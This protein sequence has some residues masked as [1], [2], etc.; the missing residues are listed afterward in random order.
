MDFQTK[1]DEDLIYVF[2]T[3]CSNNFSTTEPLDD[4]IENIHS[5]NLSAIEIDTIIDHDNATDH[6]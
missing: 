3:V 1:V 6:K 2:H 4:D 5:N